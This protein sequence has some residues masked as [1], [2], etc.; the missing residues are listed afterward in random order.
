MTDRSSPSV[1]RVKTRREFIKGIA[2]VTAAAS[3]PVFTSGAWAQ[4]RKVTIFVLSDASDATMKH[5]PIRWA[6]GQLQSVACPY[7]SL[8]HVNRRPMQL[9]P[10]G[11]GSSILTNDYCLPLCLRRE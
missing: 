7:D 10:D 2:A 3:S 9:I 6:V 8:T 1:G 11:S 4:D 5:P